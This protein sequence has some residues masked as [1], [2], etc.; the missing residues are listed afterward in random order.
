MRKIDAIG[1]GLGV[2]AVGGL[3]YIIFQVAG[4]DSLEA[5]IW[6]QVLL[7]GGLLGWVATYAYRAMGKNMTYHQQ[8]RDYEEA[9]LQKRLDELTPE[10]LAKLQAEIEEERTQV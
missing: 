1:I 10:E 7:V 2:F 9:Y 3:A 4:L 5:G 8:R 6:S